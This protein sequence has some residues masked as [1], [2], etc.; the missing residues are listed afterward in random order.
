MIITP[1]YTFD[2][3]LLRAVSDWQRGDE[4]RERGGLLGQALKAACVNL[5]PQFR[6]CTDPCYRRIKLDE[7]GLWRLLAENELGEKISSWTID[8]EVAQGMKDGIPDEG[9][10]EKMRA[11]IFQISPPPGSVIVNLAALYADEQFCT[12]MQRRASEIPSFNDGAGSYWEIEQEVVLEINTVEQANIYSMGG[13]SSDFD[14][15]VQKV[16]FLAFGL[17]M[18]TAQYDEFRTRAESVRHKAGKK[19][20]S[21]DAFQRV[22]ARVQTHI[23]RLREKKRAQDAVKATRRRD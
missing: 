5:P 4:N 8:L 12:T 13:E 2:L 6:T 11:T 10:P 18:T 20:L 9:N 19:W 15:L 22:L 17:D 16:A 7:P 23:P 21:P 1:G 14:T 3:P